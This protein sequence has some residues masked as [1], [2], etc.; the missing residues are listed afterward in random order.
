MNLRK[1]IYLYTTVLFAVLLLIMNITVYAVFSKLIYENEQAS[2]SNEMANITKIA[3][4]S[5]GNVPE[6]ELLRAFVPSNGMVR[7]VQPDKKAVTSTSPDEKALSEI[8]AEY[9]SSEFIKTM[10][11]DK[12][13]YMFASA[14]VILPDGEIG[15]FQLTRSMESAEKILRTLR[16]VLGIVTV[17]AMIP[18]LISSAILSKFITR[19]VAT[20]TATMKEI[21]KSGQF[22]RLELEGKS[23]D[24]LQQMGETFNHMIDLL[25]SNYEKQK[26]F[27]SNASH[28]LKTPLTV[29]ESYSSLLKRRGLKEPELFNESIEAI[30]SEALRMK[31]MTEQLLLLARH[32][33]QWMLDLKMMDLN[34]FLTQVIR[35]YGDAF[36]R[37]VH[38]ES[39][40]AENTFIHTDENKLKQLLFIFL[41]NA[42]KYSDDVIR[43]TAGTEQSEVYIRIEDRGMGIPQKDLPRVF[44]RFYRVD[45]ARNRKTGGSGLGLSLAKEIAD[46]LGI[47]ITLE[48]TE[49][50][51]TAASISIK[52]T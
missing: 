43:V 14:P 32:D 9:I 22:K 50:L 40:L 52:M 49:G 27:I 4:K 26:L 51:G 6:A 12:K 18:V 41:D 29:I 25:E 20:M 36:K 13:V 35:T 23:Q 16:F 34:S 39:G 7:L 37:T 28:E 3:Q 15:S 45:E 38:L 46:A 24:E 42:R 5:I 11:S 19:P 17:L 10:E 33:D 48:S 30:H 44:D 47:E 1:K 21:R 2:I 31:E 8:P